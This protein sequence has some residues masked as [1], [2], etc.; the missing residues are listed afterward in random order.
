MN[1]KI[2]GKKEVEQIEQELNL[3]IHEYDMF[4]RGYEKVEPV[5]K[6]EKIKKEILNLHNL[7][8][9]NPIIKQKAANLTQKFST[10]QRK[11]DSIWKQIE[12]GTYKIDKY[13]IK[14]NNK[15]KENPKSEN[16]SSKKQNN[17]NQKG[18]VSENYDKLLKKYEITQNLLGVKK[19]LDKES[20]SKKLNEK[21]ELLKKKYK[22]DIDFKVVVKDNKA[23]IKPV[24]KD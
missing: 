20:L 8:I 19:A 3:L 23:I 15:L 21:A 5:K 12:K 14:L 22:K 10:F 24:I 11:W 9:A 4:F 17:E 18:K 13:K 6:R 1:N 7:R 2:R 16:Q